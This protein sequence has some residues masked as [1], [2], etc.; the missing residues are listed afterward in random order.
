MFGKDFFGGEVF[1]ELDDLETLARRE[2][3]KSTEQAQAFDSAAR[4]RAELEVQF[5]REIEVLH[6]AP[7][8]SI[9]LPDPTSSHSRAEHHKRAPW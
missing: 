7:M 3:Q 6:L 9:G 2:L 1:N 4:R 5:S 8:T